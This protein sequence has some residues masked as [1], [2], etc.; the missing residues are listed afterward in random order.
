MEVTKRKT[1][2]KWWNCVKQIL[3]YAKLKSVKTGQK[4]SS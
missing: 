1:K 2:N 4:K 3:I